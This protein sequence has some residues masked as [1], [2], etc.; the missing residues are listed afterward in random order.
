MSFPTPSADRPPSAQAIPGGVGRSSLAVGLPVHRAVRGEGCYVTDETGRQLLDLNNNFTA[1]VHG[2]GHP[3][4]QAAAAAAIAEGI[5]F[6]MPNPHELEH[7]ALLASRFTHADQVV[8]AN[9]GTEAVMLAI[10]AARAQTCRPRIVFVS[11]AYHGTS[12][13]A[14]VAAGHGMESGVP[15]GVAADTI[16]VPHN[17]VDALARA[18]GDGANVAAVVLDLMPNKAG[19]L[20]LSQ[21]FVDA[22]REFTSRHDALLVLDEVISF[23]FALSGLQERYGVVPDLTAVGKLIGGGFAVGAVVGTTRAMSALNPLA[24]NALEHG[25]TFSGNP[26]TMRA[27]IASLTL[28]DRRAIDRLNTL[29]DRLRSALEPA[30]EQAGWEIRGFGSVL[31]LLPPA[32]DPDPRGRARALWWA[33]YNRGCLLMPTGML[34]LST[35]MPDDVV[36]RVT[37]TVADALDEIT[38]RRDTSPAALQ[39]PSWSASA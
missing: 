9:S 31:R 25:G 16:T 24:D 5:S 11:G 33:A 34:S 19:L 8:Y 6:G 14:L 23:R 30:A 21:E 29:G 37:S 4:I 15:S 2:H 18:I 13:V 39:V 38:V 22:A 7:A 26:V 35:A 17:D 27:G 20:P 3:A 28:L 32:D 12:D 10:R 36:N 1:L